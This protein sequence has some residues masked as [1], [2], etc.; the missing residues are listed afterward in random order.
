MYHMGALKP[1]SAAG[2]VKD[3]KFDSS[4]P[5]LCKH[6]SVTIWFIQIS[7]CPYPYINPYR[8]NSDISGIISQNWNVSHLVLQLSLPNPLKPGLGQEWPTTPQWSILLH[9]K[10]RLVLDV[11]RYMIIYNLILQWV[12]DYNMEGGSC[13]TP[14]QLVGLLCVRVVLLLNVIFNCSS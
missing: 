11:W 8:Q 7:L 1:P 9:N 3:S 5:H 13:C 2:V 10:A 6:L 12:Y 4:I 14:S